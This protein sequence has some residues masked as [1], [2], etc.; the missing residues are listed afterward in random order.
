MTGFVPTL[1]P[2]VLVLDVN[3]TLSDL[4]GLIPR[5]EEVGAPAHLLQT[6]FA[7][8]LRD[9]FALTAA[10][11]YA[12]FATVAQ[13]SLRTLLASAGPPG[14]RDPDAAADHVLAGMGELG[15][16]PDVRPGV[17]LLHRR[18]IRLI[19]L[20]NGSAQAAGEMLDQ[21]GVTPYIEQCI[22]VEEVRRWKPAPE[23]YRLAAQRTAVPLEEMMLVAVHPWDIDGAKRAGLS[24]AWINR[25]GT[26]Y[27][28]HL[29]QPDLTCSDFAALA[30]ALG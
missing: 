8:T 15:L 19:T 1:K 2:R 27:P 30:D 23:P 21:G 16:H 29:T 25:G 9:G 24:A 3:E 26:R 11:G 12:D 20:T 28:E 18:G 7:G 4:R 5:L 14:D 22:S 17:E 13:A 6:F 10:G